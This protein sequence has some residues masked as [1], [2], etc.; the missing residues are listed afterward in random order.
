MTQ[1]TKAPAL[2]GNT[3]LMKELR[4]NHTTRPPRKCD[5][6]LAALVSGRSFN[7]FEAERELHDHCLPSTVSGLQRKGIVIHRRY[8]IVPGFRGCPTDV[9]RYWLA[10]ESLQTAR[11]L[12]GNT[13]PATVP[14][15]G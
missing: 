6:V 1:K 7:R 14:P 3:G 4:T 13:V 5:R 9:C 10:P 15:E 2:A 12:L 11:K 8:E